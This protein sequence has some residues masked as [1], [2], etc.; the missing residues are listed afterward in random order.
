MV[1]IFIK[2][3]YS[4]YKPV[5]YIIVSILFSFEIILELQGQILFIQTLLAEVV[6]LIFVGK[7]SSY[8]LPN[9]RINARLA[10]I[11]IPI[12]NTFAIH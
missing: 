8:H 9:F 5:R 3:Q 2:Q 6:E 11:P 1:I 4:Q 7:V 10:I 12:P